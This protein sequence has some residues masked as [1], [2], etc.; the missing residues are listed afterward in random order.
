[1]AL[2]NP[3]LTQNPSHRRS[4][5]ASHPQAYPPQYAPMLRQGPN[6]PVPLTSSSSLL[7]YAPQPVNQIQPLQPVL[8]S[9]EGGSRAVRAHLEQATIASLNATNSLKEQL[10][11]VQNTVKVLAK[12]LEDRDKAD[13]ARNATNLQVLNQVLTA[14]KDLNKRVGQSDDERSV[15]TRLAAIEFSAGDAWEGRKDP[16]ADDSASF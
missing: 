15:M 9:I 1:M 13:D 14:L 10:T 11:D 12:R 16:Q 4:S 8:E 7:S 3:N 5:S 6:G 2:E